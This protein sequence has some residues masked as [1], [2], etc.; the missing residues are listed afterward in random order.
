VIW[1]YAV[2]TA[3]FPRLSKFARNPRQQRTSPQSAHLRLQQ[4]QQ[5][6]QQP[7]GLLSASETGEQASG[8][9]AA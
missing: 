3:L 6:Q 1:V 5:Q 9:A 4:Q 7:G 2:K 8:A